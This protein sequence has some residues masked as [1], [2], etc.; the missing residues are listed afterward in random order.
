MESLGESH[1]QKNLLALVM[2]TRML[3]FM[4][5]PMGA[6]LRRPRLIDWMK[7]NEKDQVWLANFIGVSQPTVSRWIRGGEMTHRHAHA[8]CEL[9]GLTSDDLLLVVEAPASSPSL[10][11]DADETDDAEHPAA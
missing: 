3:A 4:P 8:V 1:T 11:D 5:R 2:C 9:T 10:P 7:R 6:P